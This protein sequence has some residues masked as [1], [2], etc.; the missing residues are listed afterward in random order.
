VVTFDPDPPA[1]EMGTLLRELN[2]RIENQFASAMKLISAEA[3]RAEGT[4]AKA[5]LSNVVELLQ[6]YA[7]VHRALLKPEYDALIDAAVY[8][9]KLS[10]ALRRALLD[11]LNIQLTF[12][13]EP[14]PLQPERCW[15]LGL[16]IHELVTNA[17]KHACFDGRA[18][19]IKIRLARTDALVTCVVADNGSVSTRGGHGQGQGL[20]IT[21]DLAKG[22]GGRI[23]HGVGADFRSV[24]LAFQLTEGERQANWKIA[25][26]RIRPLRQLK[27]MAS[28]HS[29][30]VGAKSL[31]QGSRPIMVAS[32][33]DPDASPV[34]GGEAATPRRSTEVL[35]ELLSPCHRMDVL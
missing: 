11:W 12:K 28:G 16:I 19:T 6:G 14:L 18:G 33:P 1:G 3:V 20:R 4:E 2:H 24:V 8:V 7:D 34:Y 10:C 31:G 29:G 21:S 15:R 30:E 17:T 32:V 27:T 13:G 23:E 22:L 25:S 5:G 9:R 35:G 26:R